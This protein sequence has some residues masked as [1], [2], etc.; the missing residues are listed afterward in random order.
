VEEED[1][2]ENDENCDYVSL[3][4]KSADGEQE[5]K[6]EDR[7]H[8]PLAADDDSEAEERAFK[9]RVAAVTRMHPRATRLYLISRDRFARAIGGGI[10]INM[11]LHL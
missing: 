7:A 9:E 4:T 3:E 11:Q 8:Q 5:G 2:D 1:V 10:G 6:T